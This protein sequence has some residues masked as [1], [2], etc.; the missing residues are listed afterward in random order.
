MDEYLHL[1]THAERPARELASLLPAQGQW[2]QQDYLRLEDVCGGSIRAELVDG[3]LEVLP[4]P[5]Q[6]HQR[7]AGFLFIVVTAFTKANAPGLVLFSGMRVRVQNGLNPR[8][9]EPDILYMR[10]ENNQ[11]CFEEFWEGADLA[12]EVVSDSPAD[13]ARDYQE[14]ALD[15][16]RARVPEYWIID[17]Q[18]RRIRVLVLKDGVYELHGDFL[19]GMTATSV[20]LPGFSVSVNEA[21]AGGQ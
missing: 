17:P 1:L 11:R 15:Y 19:P 5:K 2:T 20:T 13:R 21:L 16:A 4:T 3:R 6:L 8:F 14:K 10:A 7:I 9:R 12:M 18:E